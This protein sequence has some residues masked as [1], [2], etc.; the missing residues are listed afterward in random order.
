MEVSMSH[1]AERFPAT[2]FRYLI[3]ASLATL[4]SMKLAI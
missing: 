2:Y 3:T 1:L 4:I